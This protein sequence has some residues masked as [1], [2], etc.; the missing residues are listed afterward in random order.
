MQLVSN[1]RSYLVGDK[2]KTSIETPNY[3]W[4][5]KS[6]HPASVLTILFTIRALMVTSLSIIWFMEAEE[7]FG[8]K[9][10]K[11]SD[12]QESCHSDVWYAHCYGF[13]CEQFIIWSFFPTFQ[14]VTVTT[15]TKSI[16]SLISRSSASFLSCLTVL[17]LVM[18]SWLVAW[19]DRYNSG[20]KEATIK[21]D[22]Q[23]EYKQNSISP[24]TL[25]KQWYIGVFCVTWFAYLGIVQFHEGWL[26]T[27]CNYLFMRCNNHFGWFEFICVY[28][29]RTKKKKDTHSLVIDFN[30][31]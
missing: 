1:L 3:M 21:M 12:V 13:C 30:F 17:Q 19:D 31:R 28:I 9:F 4:L 24:T 29:A 10:M 18:E 7:T 8:N 23:S 11:L 6:N 16:G 5:Y 27:I 2:G 22:I 26:L 15:V 20:P 14:N 25:G